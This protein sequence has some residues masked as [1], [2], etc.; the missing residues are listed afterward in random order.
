MVSL[1][2][3]FSFLQRKKITFLISVNGIECYVCTTK[4][5]EK[6]LDPVKYNL[7][8]RECTQEVLTETKELATK[9]NKKFSLP[10]DISI[11]TPDVPLKCLKTVT[12]GELLLYY[13]LTF[14]N[15]LQNFIK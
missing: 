3:T 7:E 5:N 13:L 9:L 12:K 11:I 10:F 1:T 14:A 2:S 6:C 15:S 8:T 4:T